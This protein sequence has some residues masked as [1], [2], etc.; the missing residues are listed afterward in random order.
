MAVLVESQPTARIPLPWQIVRGVDTTFEIPIYQSGAT[1]LAA[2]GGDWVVYDGDGAEFDSG[3]F[4]AAAV[5]SLEVEGTDTSSLEL[6]GGWLVTGNVTH[7][8]GSVPF[9]TDAALVRTK[10]SPVIGDVDV[11]RRCKALDP[12]SARAISRRT[13]FQAELDEAWVEINQRLIDNGRRPWLILSPSSLRQVHLLLTIALVF[14]DLATRLE[15]AHGDRAREF[16]RLYENAWT[17]L[18]FKYDEGND[19][20]VPSGRR[21]GPAVIFTTGRR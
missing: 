21:S 13:E 1:A 18:S 10:L 14:E 16:R 17:R 8:G 4:A 3:T 11:A 20:Q 2:T 7:A 5:A 19:Q 12:S 15:P 6:G 9:R